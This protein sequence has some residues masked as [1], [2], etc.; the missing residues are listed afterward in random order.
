MDEKLARQHLLV[1]I[2]TVV[3]TKEAAGKG[4]DLQRAGGHERKWIVCGRC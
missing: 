4:K 2:I 1:A 3:V